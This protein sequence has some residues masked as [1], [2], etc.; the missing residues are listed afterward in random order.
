[1]ASNL[2]I[3]L[4]IHC[5]PESKVCDIRYKWA[6]TSLMHSINCPVST[7]TECVPEWLCHRREKFTNWVYYNQTT[8]VRFIKSDRLKCD[9]VYYNISCQYIGI[10][11][12]ACKCT[13]IFWHNITNKFSVWLKVEFTPL[14]L[15]SDLKFSYKTHL[16][17]LLRW[18]IFMC[19]FC[20][21]VCFSGQSVHNTY[22][23]FNEPGKKESTSK[24]I[25]IETPANYSIPV[26]QRTICNFYSKWHWQFSSC[27]M[28]QKGYH[29]DHKKS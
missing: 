4:D 3:H 12:N 7:H 28:Y 15:A 5:L 14:I 13:R 22:V 18:T 27:E 11:C 19:N 25:V 20:L 1:M 29:W 24:T 21:S 9:W 16:I 10:G 2:G 6:F 26:C 23:T 17:R 8:T